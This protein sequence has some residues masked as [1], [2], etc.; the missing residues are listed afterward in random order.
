MKDPMYLILKSLNLLLRRLSSIFLFVF[1][2][3]FPDTTPE[4]SENDG[5]LDFV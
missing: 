5:F 2:N 3:Y 1:I 4:E